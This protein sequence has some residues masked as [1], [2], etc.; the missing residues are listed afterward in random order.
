MKATVKESEDG[1][2]VLRTVPR[3]RLWEIHTPQVS[4][5]QLF[6]KGFAK[7][8]ENNLEVTDGKVIII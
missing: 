6:L 2:F 8:K 1:Q 4:T 5:K 3:S 7:V